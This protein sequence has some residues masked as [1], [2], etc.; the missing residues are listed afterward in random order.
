[1]HKTNTLKLEASIAAVL[2]ITNIQ[3][4]E[5]V[6]ITITNEDED[7]KG[8]YSFTVFN[9]PA[10]N[11]RQQIA[12]A[13]TTNAKELLLTIEPTVQQLDAGDHYY[14]IFNSLTKRVEFKGDLEIK[15]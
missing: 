2:D 7:W 9:S 12:S 10:K 1:M 3:H 4:A 8:T 14:E 15:L 6:I 13:V 11:S 5:K